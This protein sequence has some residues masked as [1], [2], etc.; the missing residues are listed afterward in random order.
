MKIMT[1]SCY[2][3]FLLA[4]AVSFTAAAGQD[5]I[6]SPADDGFGSE[7]FGGDDIIFGA[8]GSGMDDDFA[9]FMLDEALMESGLMMLDQCNIDL[10]KLMESGTAAASL[11]DPSS[12]MDLI[13][14][15]LEVV[16]NKCTAKKASDF[17][18]AMDSFETCAGVD[19][20]EVIEVFPSA[21]L[22][23]DLVCMQSTLQQFSAENSTEP[24]HL[25]EECA[26]DLFGGNPLGNLVRGL[27]LRPDHIIPCF[28]TLSESL[29][30]CTLSVWPMP[31]V[32]P[33]LK[34]FSCLIGAAAP[35]L[36]QMCQAELDI[37][38][39]CLPQAGSSECDAAAVD[40]AEQESSMFTLPDPLIGAPMSDACRRVAGAHDM[41]S[42][43]ERYEKTTSTCVEAWTGWTESDTTSVT[44]Q[45]YMTAAKAYT[46]PA[47]TGST[48]NKLSE[49]KATQE[50]TGTE[51]GGSGLRMFIIGVGTGL[52]I[53]CVA[54]ALISMK[55]PKKRRKGFASVE[56]VESDLSLV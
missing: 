32:G 11:L 34:D 31:V 42:V 27:Y 16:G 28:V 9:S 41:S 19:L 23:M 18:E 51:S 47:A 22:G 48:A 5:D 38:D 33:W 10:D 35:F 43:V 8:D 54:W 44:P 17:K 56:M 12:T 26:E 45:N 30:D 15:F 24:V 52:T 14:S 21:L 29:P 4:A 50:A 39:S 46:S 25:G 55:S 7:L 3:A 1:R 53:V 13:S 2:T 20:M 37:L 36:D 49:G 40:C 6:F